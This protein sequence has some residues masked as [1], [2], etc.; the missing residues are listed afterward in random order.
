MREPEGT[1]LEFSYEERVQ[2]LLDDEEF[3]EQATRGEV[4]I[5]LALLG[6]RSELQR[7]AWALELMEEKNGQE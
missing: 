3:N 6:I 7:I 1:S 2:H 5:A 4:A